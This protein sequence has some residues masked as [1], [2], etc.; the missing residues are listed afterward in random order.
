MH[1]RRDG[2]IGHVVRPFHHLLDFL[3][4]G[5]HRPLS[6]TWGGATAALWKSLPSGL[7]GPGPPKSLGS[8][9]APHPPTGLARA[10]FFTVSL[11]LHR[12]SRRP[13]VVV[14]LRG[15]EVW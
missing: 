14:V 6:F 10:D 15:I 5:S 3:D 9:C 13:E 11:S 1:R 12:L 8:P 2:G 4:L 7:A